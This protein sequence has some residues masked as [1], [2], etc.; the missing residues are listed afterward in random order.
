[1]E[2]IRV[3]DIGE[4]MKKERCLYVVYDIKDDSTRTYLA[5]RLLYFGLRRVQYSVFNGTVSLKD[6]Q[7]LLDEIEAID[8]N[9]EDKIHIIDLCERCR[10]NVVVIGEMPEDREHLVI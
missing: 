7:L 5:N 6:M 4:K 1:M 8:L 9:Q 2:S 3:F 10:K